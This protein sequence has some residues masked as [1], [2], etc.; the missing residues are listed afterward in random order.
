MTLESYSYTTFRRSEYLRGSTTR[1]LILHAGARGSQITCHLEFLELGLSSSRSDGSFKAKAYEALS[2]T[3]GSTEDPV[4]IRID[5]RK[6]EVR[7]NLWSALN[8]LKMPRKARALW[9]DA[10]C[11]NQNDVDERSEQVRKMG[12]IYSRAT[13]VIVWLGHATPDSRVTFDFLRESKK[14]THQNGTMSRAKIL[15]DSGKFRMLLKLCTGNYWQR[16]WIVQEITR[17]RRLTIVCGEYQVSWTYLSDMFAWLG[18]LEQQKLPAVAVALQ[19]SI[20]AKLKKQREEFRTGSTNLSS[21]LR[22]CE[23]SRC[24]VPHDK[25]YGFLGL[26]SDY[27]GGEDF[28]TVDYSKSLLEVHRDLVNFYADKKRHLLSTIK[29][30]SEPDTFDLFSFSIFVS[31]LLGCHHLRDISLFDRMWTGGQIPLPLQDQK[32]AYTLAMGLCTITALEPLDDLLEWQEKLHWL[33]D[34]VLQDEL[35]DAGILVYKRSK[36]DTILRSIL[37]AEICDFFAEDWKKDQVKVL[38]LDSATTY[39]TFNDIPEM[40]KPWPSYFRPSPPR[41]GSRKK[42]TSPPT[43]QPISKRR[44]EQGRRFISADGYIGVVPLSAD[45]GDVLYTVTDSLALLVSCDTN[46]GK[47][48]G[49]AYVRKSPVLPIRTTEVMPLVTFHFD[50]STFQLLTTE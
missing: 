42:K 28:F 44:Y 43:D 41:K 26:A 18:T 7:Q 9:V 21:I 19:Q 33:E 32:L 6:F 14:Y 10:I 3:W 47:V 39:I 45:V 16:V 4:E 24:A 37:P 27:K 50:M 17:A 36:K 5:N 30:H 25:I 2:Y 38:H 13:Q 8:A 48:K 29:R 34:V 46:I 1:I 31:G 22:D 40:T 15:R 20:P 49:A 11:I 23:R 12:R 35:E